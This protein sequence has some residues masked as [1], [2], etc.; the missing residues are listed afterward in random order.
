MGM[1]SFRSSPLKSQK[2]RGFGR[3]YKSSLP[4]SSGQA[5]IEY[6]LILIVAMV[7]LGTLAT[8]VFQPLGEFVDKV[9]RTY[10]Q[11]LLE[12]GELPSLGNENQQMACADE[13]PTLAIL[14]SEGKPIPSRRPGSESDE[15]KENSVGNADTSGAAAEEGASGGGRAVAAPNRKSSVIRNGMRSRGNAQP[16]IA[17]NITTIPVENFEEGNGYMNLSS[18]SAYRRGNR[19]KTRSVAITGLMEYERRKIERE[20]QKVTTRAPADNESFTRPA[21]KKLLVKP[22][23]SKEISEDQEMDVGFGFYIKI[24]FIIIII[25]FIVILF[26][27]QALQLS[28]NWE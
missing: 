28:K 16:E 15:S 19:S 21:N 27:G 23:P 9:N 4:S 26:G 20:Q 8:T 22:P 10:I 11:C 3:V 13:F 18:S 17:G 12:T 6:L 14:D 5:I 1:K 24:F 7:I 2:N 25:L